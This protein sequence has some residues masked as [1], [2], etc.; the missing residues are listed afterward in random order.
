MKSVAKIIVFLILA[1]YF[2]FVGIYGMVNDSWPSIMPL[3]ID[4][5]FIPI[6]HLHNN[7][8]FLYGGF[9]YLVIATV[10][11]FVSYNAVKKSK[12]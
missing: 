10:L 7:L 11:M 12:T 9:I 6:T 1:I 8:G 5:L 3:N 4:V 2:V